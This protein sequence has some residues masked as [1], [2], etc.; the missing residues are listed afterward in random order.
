MRGLQHWLGVFIIILGGNLS[1]WAQSDIPIE[2]WRTHFSYQ[3]SRLIVTTPERVYVAS[4]HGLFYLTKSDNSLQ[5]LSK[6]DGLTDIEVTAMYFDEASGNLVLAYQSGVVDLVTEKGVFPLTLIRDEADEPEIIYDIAVQE[7]TVYLATTAGVRVLTIDLEQEEPLQ[8]R[9]SYTRLSETGDPLVI[10]QIEML[11]DSLFLATE[12]GVLANT[13]DPAVN[14]QDYNT[15]QRF[16]I[17]GGLSSD[18][19]FHLTSWNGNVYAALNQQGVYRF[20]EGQWQLTAFTTEGVFSGLQSSSEGVLI[21]VDGR[22]FR[23]EASGSVVSLENEAISAAQDAA[24]EGATLWVADQQQGLIRLENGQVERFLPNGPASD[25]IQKLRYLN[26]KIVA[27]QASTPGQFYTFTDGQ[28]QNFTQLPASSRLMDAAYSA[29]TQQYYFATFGEGILQWDGQEE[30]SSLTQ[31]SSGGNL[32]NNQATAL[33]ANN[34]F[35][36]IANYN[37]PASLQRLDLQNDTWQSVTFSQPQAMYPRQLTVDFRNQVWMLVGNSDVNQPGTDL[38]VFSPTTEEKASFRSKVNPSE[39]PGSQISDVALDLDGQLWLAGSEGVGYFPLPELVFE[40]RPL[41]QRPVFERQ[42][43]L[44]GV[45]ITAVAVDG[46]NRKWIGTNDGLWL[47]SDTAEELF[48]QFTTENSPLIS[49]VIVDVAVNDQSGEVFVATDKGVVSFRS[50]STQGSVTH[51]SV[52]IFPNPVRQS[53]D[54]L[55]GIEGLVNQATVKITT[56]SGVLVQELQAEGGTATWNVK[57]YTGET[58]QP[59]V[60]LVFSASPDGT[61]TFVGKIAVVP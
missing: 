17:D 43:L 11:G 16:L 39:L 13:L 34:E 29:N 41:P 61:E 53:F 50:T 8:I 44:L 2:A 42:F 4:E 6:S 5:V 37:T 30:F 15:W 31:Q 55:V 19:V 45:N 12:E 58:V 14:Q 46:G 7:S 52:K 49:N 48:Y 35:L 57:A 54:G 27:L 1:L 20:H 59:G 9:E 33:A 32:P 18:P 56:V 36:W 51:Q 38:F 3:D 23:L 28:W 10:Y 24:Q 22:V 40:E 47:F 60:Y 25:A 21:I 26:G